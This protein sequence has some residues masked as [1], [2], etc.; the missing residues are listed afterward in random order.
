MNPSVVKVIV[1]NA[2]DGDLISIFGFNKAVEFTK[3]KWFVDID[4]DS[5]ILEIETKNGQFK[6]DIIDLDSIKHINITAPYKIGMDPI[7]K[8]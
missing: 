2:D 3:E 5:N 1:D 4:E 6:N 7:M 8:K